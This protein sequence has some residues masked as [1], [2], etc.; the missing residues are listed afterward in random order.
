MSTTSLACRGPLAGAWRLLRGGARGV[1]IILVAAVVPV[2]SAAQQQAILNEAALAGRQVEFHAVAH[3]DTIYVGQQANYQVGVFLGD[4]VRARLRRNPEFVPPEMSG[5]LGY[6]LPVTHVMMRGADGM[7]YEAHVFERAIFPLA[8]GAIRIP[9]A[10]LSYSLPL[11]RSFFSREESFVLRTEPVSLVA[12]P[13]PAEGQPADFSGAVGSDLGL[14]LEVDAAGARVGNGILVTGRLSGVGNVGLLPR[15]RLEVGWGT[16][17]DA[18]ERVVLD[19]TARAIGGTKEFDWLVTPREPGGWSLPELRYSYFDPAVV[20]YRTALAPAESVYVGEGV[21]VALD[22]NVVAGPEPMALRGRYRGSVARPP[23]THPVYWLAVALLPLP[24]VVTRLRRTRRGGTRTITAR[25]RLRELAGGP[26]DVDRRELSRGQARALRATLLRALADRLGSRELPC[27]DARSFIR[28]LRLEGVSAATATAAAALVIRLDHAAFSSDDAQLPAASEPS[29]MAHGTS[30]PSADANPSATGAPRTLAAEALAILGAVD[31]EA[32]GGVAGAEP[33]GR[34]GGAGTM[35]GRRGRRLF[36]ATLVIV[37]GSGALHL[38]AGSR[39]AGAAP[40]AQPSVGITQEPAA[41]GQ[42][43][44]VTDAARDAFDWGVALYH[45]GDFAAARDSFAAAA[46]IA[47]RSAD[48]WANSGTAAWAAGDTAAAA[49]GWQRAVRLQPAARDVRVRLHLLP[50]DQL[51]GAASVP[52]IPVAF[53]Q[54]GAL[55]GWAAAWGLAFWSVAAGGP[56]L[57]AWVGLLLVLA[58]LAGGGAALLTERAAARDLYV[59]MPGSTLRTL[60]ALSAPAQRPLAAGE[61]VRQRA[62]AGVWSRITSGGSTG[63]VER[64]Q[65]RALRTE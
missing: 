58:A 26:G 6:D 52:A 37:I 27:R 64:Q 10:R 44:S 32:R 42:D 62:S 51:T 1:A 21:I 5:V 19:T 31:A 24:A 59:V 41:S 3:P 39:E 40:S 65:L 13:P 45:A 16:V 60:P 49:I 23:A 46:R 35:V 15:P 25:D 30:C 2:T 28:T 63:W 53:A 14:R 18:G 9:P 43:G 7:S 11:S 33:T 47:P 38:V 20:A 4:E 17:V 12:L 36:N 8:A 48:A 34:R 29:R 61:V 55:L 56:L 50:G 54:W 57:T 22:S